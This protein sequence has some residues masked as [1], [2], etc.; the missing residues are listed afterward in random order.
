MFF[1]K[2]L[3]QNQAYKFSAS[4][5]PETQGEVLSITNVVLAPASKET[6]SLYIKKG[7]DEFLVATLT[8]ERPQAVVNLFISLLD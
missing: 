7:S 6:G 3:S 2:V 4:E 8:K 1:G 5:A